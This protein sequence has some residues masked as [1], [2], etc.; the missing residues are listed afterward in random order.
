MTLNGK[1]AGTNFFNPSAYVTQYAINN[2]K[3]GNTSNGLYVTGNASSTNS[4][5]D[6]I[7]IKLSWGQMPSQNPNFNYITA[8]LSLSSSS[9][10]TS[11]G[12]IAVANSSA[13]GSANKQATS[14]TQ[15]Q[16]GQTIYISQSISSLIQGHNININATSSPYIYIGFYLNQAAGAPADTPVANLTVSNFAITTYPIAL[17][18]NSTG[19]TI[20]QAVNNAYLQRFVPT[21]PMN[22]QNDSY[23]VAVQ[24][25]MTN[26]T[27][28][29]TSINDGSFTEQAT[30]QGILQ[31][32]AAPDL[33]YSPSNVSLALPI[34][35]SQYEVA[36]LNGVS[37]LTQ[38]QNKTNGTFSFGSVNPNS[39]NS[40][41]LEVKY[42]TAQWDASS[43]P[44]SFFSLAGLEYYWWATLIAIMSFVGLGSV[45]LSHFGADEEGLR[46]PKGKFGR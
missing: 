20:T 43:A 5:F 45:A 17:G 28:Q 33:T 41:V 18:Q 15:A 12:T 9:G 3:I 38:I 36:N 2:Y 19:Q 29:Q 14:L 6:Y 1:Y 8:T 26:L 4:L 44:P 42:T 11:T 31:L 10:A 24:E 34:P 39:Q 30:Y 46:I 32:P 7:L 35:G 40:L 16:E 22:I 25:P 13:A 27:E 37:F 21:V 23:S